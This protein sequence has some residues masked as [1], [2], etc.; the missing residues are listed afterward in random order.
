VSD[1]RI[2]VEDAVRD[3]VALHQRGQLEEAEVFYQGVLDAVP[4]H[5]DALHFLGVMRSQ[6]GKNSEA[7]KLIRKAIRKAPDHPGMRLN[8]GNVLRELERWEESEASYREAIGMDPEMADAYCNLGALLRARGDL[9]GAR[10]A[11]NRAIELNAEHAEA[12]CNLG[13]ML[14]DLEE[15]EQAVGCYR[16]AVDLGG[17]GALHSVAMRNMANML[18]RSGDLEGAEKTVRQWVERAPDNETAR[19]MLAAFTQ[20][21]VPARAADGYVKELFNGF[22]RSFDDVLESLD[23]KAPEIVA[24][25]VEE[26]QPESGRDVLDL[27]CGTGLSGVIVASR[28]RRLAGVDISPMMLAKAE[29]RQV[30]DELVE[31]EITDYLNTVDDGRFHIVLAVDTLCYFGEL[32][33]VLAGVARCLTNDGIFCFTVEKAENSP[34]N[35]G[36][37]LERHGRY[38]HQESYLKKVSGENGLDVVRL[39]ECLLRFEGGRPVSGFAV[40]LKRASGD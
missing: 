28:A 37:R 1:T 20:E 23:Y 29:N 40:A 6:T 24:A 9:D 10:E 27:G 33:E 3:G 19:H 22:A 8:L 38:A 34:E 36:F 13:H 39:N 26:L 14:R 2:S 32:R 5:A 35:R 21:E 17:S 30:Y 31:S 18:Y 11:L 12:W 16:K 4:D 7:A 15:F 25:L